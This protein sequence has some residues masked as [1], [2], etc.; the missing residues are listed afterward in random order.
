MIGIGLDFGTSNSTAAWFDGRQVHLV[1]LERDGPVLPTA[2]HL[3]REFHALTGQ[4][5]IDRYIDENRGR[6]V[7]MVAEVIGEA[8]SGITGSES[9]EDITSRLQTQRNLV[10][11]PLTDRGQPGRLFHGLK[12]LLGDPALERVP[13]FGRQFRLVALITPILLRMRQAIEADAG[14][15]ALPVMAGRPVHFEGSGQHNDALAQ[16]RLAEAFGHAGLQGLAFREEPIGATLSYLHQARPQR[17]GLA[18]TVDFGG[19][20]LDL[21]VVHHDG[22]RFEVLGTAGLALGG[23]KIDQLIFARLLFPELGKGERWRRVVDGSVIDTVFPFEEYETALL[24][25]PI[26]HTLNQNR[27][28][29]MLVDRMAQPDLAAEKF[30]RLHDLVCFNEGY[31]CF[32]AIRRAKVALSSLE[33]TDIDIPE[34]NLRVPFTRARFDA[35]LAGPLLQ[36]RE[37]VTGLLDRLQLPATAIDTVI[38]TGGTSQIVAV[39]QLLE[40]LFPGRVVAHDPFTSVAAGLAIASYRQQRGG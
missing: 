31:T 11:G 37:L 40:D 9:G 25:W 27:T 8:A 23:D 19:G 18:L 5:A 24:H 17:P 3:D 22:D 26:T 2:L 6:R 4:D 29:S 10:F 16:G 30:R 20:T 14:H 33:A 32:R 38:R 1:R 36:T 35:L 15:P 28:K 13:V 7:E 12:R 39:R 21:A 34:L